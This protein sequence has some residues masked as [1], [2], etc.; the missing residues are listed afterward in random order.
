M[1]LD[2]LPIAPQPDRCLAVVA[3]LR[4]QGRRF[5]TSGGR[6]K[7]LARV[8]IYL[9]HFIFIVKSMFALIVIAVD[10]GN[11]YYPYMYLFHFILI[12]KSMFALIVV[13]VDGGNFSTI[14]NA[15]VVIVSTIIIVTFIFRCS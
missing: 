12:M 10:G 11:F 9:F 13:A 1:L 3:A 14:C 4:T 6:I 15:V 5:E 7:L 2:F 8:C